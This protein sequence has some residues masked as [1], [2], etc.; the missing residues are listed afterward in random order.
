MASPVLSQEVIT[1]N[2]L[3]GYNLNHV[4][5]D[6]AYAQIRERLGKSEVDDATAVTIASWWAGHDAAGRV[7]AQLSTTATVKLG[8]LMDAIRAEYWECRD[9]RDREALD[10]L[11]T[12]ALKHPSRKP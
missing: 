10:M 5:S 11:A 9:P 4:T 8:E 6:V 12:W 3:I 7:M 2:G 1:A